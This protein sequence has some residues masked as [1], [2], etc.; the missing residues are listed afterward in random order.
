M[1]PDVSVFFVFI[2]VVYTFTT[3]NMKIFFL[4]NGF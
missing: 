4:I 1:K 3:R 2:F